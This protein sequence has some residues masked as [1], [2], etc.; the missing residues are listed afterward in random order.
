ME[1]YKD[2][3]YSGVGGSLLWAKDLIADGIV[4]GIGIVSAISIGT[5]LIVFAAIGTARAELPAIIV[6][7]A[8]LLIVLGVSLTFNL[9]RSAG[10]KQRRQQRRRPSK[11]ARDD[12]RPNDRSV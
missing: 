9:A 4:H 12:A 5:V 6:Y 1:K 3:R 7:I 2:D 11:R 8:T 10:F